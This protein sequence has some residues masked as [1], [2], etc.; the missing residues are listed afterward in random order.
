VIED[1]AIRAR[2]FSEPRGRRAPIDMFFRS[3]AAGRGDGMAVVLSG[4]GSDGAFGVRK[5][6]EGG[7][8]SSSSRSRARPSSG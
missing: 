7:A 8:A 5:V 3:I 1:N 2:P 6:K 4:A